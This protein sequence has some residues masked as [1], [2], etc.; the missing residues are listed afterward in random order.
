MKKR[1]T[2]CALSAVIAVAMGVGG[3]AGVATAQDANNEA[4]DFPNRPVTLITWS[5]AG[6]PI[7]ILTRTIAQ[8]LSEVW[9]QKVLVENRTGATGVIATQHAAR[10]PADGYH[11]LM[12]TSTAHIANLYLQPSLSYDPKTDFEPVA[13]L[14]AGSVVLMAPANAPF[15]DIDGLAEYARKQGTGMSYGTWGIGSSAHLYGELLKTKY[16]VPLVHVPY[17][18]DVASTQDLVGGTLP[19]S[20]TGGVT[21][22]R[23]IEGG[24]AKALAQAAAER[25]SILPDVP[26]FKEQGYEGFDLMGWAGVFVPA[27]VPEPILAKISADLETV[28]KSPEVSKRLKDIGQDEIYM[29][30][31]TMKEWLDSEFENWGQLIKDAGVDKLESK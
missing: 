15:N 29:D 8:G 24:Q 26:T 3:A 12:T 31:A 11:L 23:L 10:L 17:R 21:A 13:R 4:A 25:F 19:V 14:A 6:G 1:Y 2:R 22:R 9:N 27:G 20:F 5:P 18:G 7:D 30:H 28:V 16:N